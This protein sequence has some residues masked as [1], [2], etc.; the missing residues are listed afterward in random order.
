MGWPMTPAIKEELQKIR[1][2]LIALRDEA[3]MPPN[4]DAGLA[5]GL[6]HTVRALF[7]TIEEK[8]FREEKS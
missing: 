1:T 2:R 4:L 8:E 5:V 6:S 3:L 7:F